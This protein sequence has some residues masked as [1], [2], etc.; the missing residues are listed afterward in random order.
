MEGVA[1]RS[2]RDGHHRGVELEDGDAERTCKQG[3]GTALHG[4]IRL[5]FG[6]RVL[7][8]AARSSS[9]L[10]DDLAER[11]PFEGVE[12]RGQIVEAIAPLDHRLEIG[13]V[14]R[15]DEVLQ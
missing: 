6:G 2:E 12:R 7:A 10:D 14:D 5:A 3:A 8:R 15:A 11:T 13:A 1:Q 4:G 9:D